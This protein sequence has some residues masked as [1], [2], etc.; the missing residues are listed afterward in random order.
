MASKY[1][2]MY[3]YVLFPYFPHFLRPLIKLVI[4]QFSLTRNH[5]HFLSSH[6]V[7]VLRALHTEL[8]QSGH[9]ELST[10]IRVHFDVQFVSWI[11]P[12]Q[13]PDG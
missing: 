5:L 8:S 12:Q 10:A 4:D 11:L 9:V 1:F 6:P 7:D 13:V 2:F 3:D